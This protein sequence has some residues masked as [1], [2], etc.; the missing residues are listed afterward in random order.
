[1][2]DACKEAVWIRS[3]I[4]NLGVV[5]HMEKVPLYMDNGYTLLRP[6]AVIGGQHD[7]TAKR[8]V[9]LLDA[10]PVVYY[11]RCTTHYI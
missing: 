8:D 5:P 1:M 9:R 2:L 7:G 4:N 3:F 11:I 10:W 6:G